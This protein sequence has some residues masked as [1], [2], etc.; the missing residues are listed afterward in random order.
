[1]T[2]YLCSGLI[3]ALLVFLKTP[4]KADS[5]PEIAMIQISAPISHGS[6]AS[7]VMDET[8]QVFGIA[9]LGRA[10]GQNLNFA[11]PVERVLSAPLM[12]SP[13]EQV[14][15]AA[16]PTPAIDAKAPFD[17]GN[18]F[19][20]KKEYNKAISAFTEAIRLDPNFAPAYD[21]RGMAYAKQGNLD[22]ASADFATAKRLKA[23]Q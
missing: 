23:G 13:S 18:A 20:D 2:K 4:S 21:D 16:L 8:G 6:S 22:K 5:I 10:E 17:S 19:F 11:I 3:L 14:A 1:M 15:C 7:P 9:T 12:E